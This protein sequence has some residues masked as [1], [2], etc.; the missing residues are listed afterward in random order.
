MASLVRGI[1]L[2]A[3]KCNDFSSSYYEATGGD[4]GD[5]TNYTHLILSGH[6]VHFLRKYRNLY[7]YANQGWEAMNQKIKA[8]FFH[9]SNHG[10]AAG[11]KK[12]GCHGTN[13]HLVAIMRMNQRTM[14]WVLG[15]GDEFFTRIDN[16]ELEAKRD[17]NTL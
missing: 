1:G 15:I 17:D 9:N 11:S 6:L 5:M 3:V 12:G 4:R 16:G 14:M 13:N 8:F 10:G 7:K 2:G